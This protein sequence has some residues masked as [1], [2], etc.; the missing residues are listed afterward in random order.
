[1]H[2]NDV[3]GAVREG[4]AAARLGL[5]RTKNPYAGVDGYASLAQAW[6][7]GYDAEKNRH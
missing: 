7:S 4:R 3:V 2:H 1:M 6:Y 5:D